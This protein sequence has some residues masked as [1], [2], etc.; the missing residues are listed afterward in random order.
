VAAVRRAFPAPIEPPH[1]GDKTWQSTDEIHF[2]QAQPHWSQI[3]LSTDQWSRCAVQFVCLCIRRQGVAGAELLVSR[4][5]AFDEAARTFAAFRWLDGQHVDQLAVDVKEAHTAVLRLLDERE[6]A[7][8]A[9]DYM[10]LDSIIIA[11]APALESLRLADGQA[12]ADLPLDGLSRL[13]L[14]AWHVANVLRELIA[15]HRERLGPG[16]VAYLVGMGERLGLPHVEVAR[17]LVAMGVWPVDA[18]G[19]MVKPL[20]ERVAENKTA[21]IELKAA[22]AEAVETWCTRLRAAKKRGKDRAA[23][24]TKQHTHRR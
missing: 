7:Q 13:A 6:N 22:E 9:L 12:V 2:L 4:L 21:L 23:K 3:G 15:P 18:E 8:R 10:L 11:L 1:L 20:L 5:V 16:P 24:R 17:R 19:A 14:T